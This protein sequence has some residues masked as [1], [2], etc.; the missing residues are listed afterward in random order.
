LEGR[1][2]PDR[3]ERGGLTLRGP[4]SSGPAEI[5]LYDI[6]GRQ[7]G[8]FTHNGGQTMTISNIKVPAENY[9]LVVRNK[10]SRNDLYKTRVSFVK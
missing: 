7:A 6:S 2:I 9:V 8:K 10:A 1:R 3:D 4:L 5:A